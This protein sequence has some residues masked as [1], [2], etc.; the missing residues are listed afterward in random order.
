ML[1]KIYQAKSSV[2]GKINKI[3]IQLEGEVTLH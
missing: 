3:R 1:L 2:P